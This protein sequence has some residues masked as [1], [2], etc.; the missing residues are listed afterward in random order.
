MECAQQLA[1]LASCDREKISG[2]GR[3]ALS[4]LQVHRM[5]FERPIVTS[6]Y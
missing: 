6:K 1:S 4:A 2:L 5:L 3:I